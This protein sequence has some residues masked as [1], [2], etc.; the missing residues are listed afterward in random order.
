MYYMWSKVCIY[1]VFVYNMKLLPWLRTGICLKF[2][3][4]FLSAKVI[5]SLTE[6]PS[7]IFVLGTLFFIFNNAWKNPKKMFLKCIYFSES[8]FLD[9]KLK[10][11]ISTLLRL[12]PEISGTSGSQS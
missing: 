1:V 9:Y 2:S 4:R 12:W 11:F 10:M 5:S 3:L 6:T 8:S 7:F